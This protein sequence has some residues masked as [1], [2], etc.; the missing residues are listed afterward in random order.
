VK[1]ELETGFAP[2]NGAM[3]PGERA[4]PRRA[5][6]EP[7][8]LKE[9]L[10]AAGRGRWPP[11]KIIAT[12]GRHNTRMGDLPEDVSFLPKPYTPEG[13]SFLLHELAGGV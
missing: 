5:E 1:S 12:S 2:G 7:D 10:A 8:Y 6:D 4:E 3:R 9:L 11:I 13:I